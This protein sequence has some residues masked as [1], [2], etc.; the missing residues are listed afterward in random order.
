[1]LKAFQKYIQAKSL[2]DFNDRILL[3]ISGGIDS[4]VMLDLFKKA[5]FIFEVAHCNFNL[6]EKESD[7]DEEFVREYCRK[8][9]IIFHLASFDTQ[10]ESKENK[11]SIEETARN[12]RYSWFNE[13]LKSNGLNYVATAHH[14]N[15]V[16]ETILL[17][18]SRGTGIA[19]LHGI[20]PKRNTLIRPM[21]FTSKLDIE[22][23][24]QINNVKFVFD[25]SN[26]SMEHTRNKIRHE[27]IPAFNSLNPDFINSSNLLA[28]YVCETESLLNYFINDIRKKSFT[29]VDNYICFDISNIDEKILNQTLLF[30]LLR[31][32]GFNSSQS[33]DIHASIGK[34]GLSFQTNEYDLFIDRMQIL[35]K[36]KSDKTDANMHFIIDRLPCKIEIYGTQYIFNLIERNEISDEDLKAKT[37][38]HINFDLLELPL[39][40]RQPKEGEK[41][42]PF[43]LKGSKK[44]SDYLTDKKLNVIVKHQL[45]G[46]YQ[47]DII[48]LLGLEIDNKFAINN[49]TKKILRIERF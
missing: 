1:M 26:N 27:L 46:L 9:N 39:D 43:G 44:I 49:K 24:A 8:N 31:P 28:N 48:G 10:T 6:R 7:K 42:S 37:I 25:H 13:L 17:N 16:S 3:A 41:F 34:S 4:M 32:F 45:L 11:L 12:L 5:E 38:Q 18:L 2:F 19:G 29:K 47:V 33:F 40:I 20:M 35:I 15:D 14:K 21:L 23:Y 22:N 36:S 30:E